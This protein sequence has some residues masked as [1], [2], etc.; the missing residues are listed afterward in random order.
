MSG[1]SMRKVKLIDISMTLT[2]GMPAWPGDPVFRRIQVKKIGGKSRANLSRLELCSHSG[3]HLDAPYH[4]LKKGR[5]ME[6]I[7][8][9]NCVLPCYVKEV[10][11]REIRPEDMR[12]LS[13]RKYPAL[14]FRTENSVRRLLNRKRFVRDFVSLSPEAAVILASSPVRLVGIDYLSIEQ[15]RGDGTVHRTLLKKG[16]L[17][18]E[19]L[20]LTRVREGPY[21]LLA[22]PLK[23]QKGDGAPS[24][25]LL[26]KTSRLF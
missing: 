9:E 18:L 17:I 12:N 7:P 16:I 10:K 19:G 22:L 5:G 1:K 25:C 4:F 14:L 26:L 6:N 2:D 23:I 20:D 3:T 15:F 21:L 13:F 11:G 8:V 24:R